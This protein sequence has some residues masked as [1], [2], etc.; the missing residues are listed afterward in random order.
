AMP[1]DKFLAVN[2]LKAE[3][4][5]TNLDV[6]DGKIDVGGT[7]YAKETGLN[8]VNVEYGVEKIIKRIVVNTARTFGMNAGPIYR[9]QK[10]EKCIVLQSGKILASGNS[11]LYWYAIQDVF[12]DSGYCYFKLWNGAPDSISDNN[13]TSPMIGIVST[14]TNPSG[15]QGGF[16]IR[17]N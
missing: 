17:V 7:A 16:A 14:S 9:L 13:V 1:A 15:S 6:V 4:Y 11:N 2:N 5:R 8:Y 10:D 12:E 3:D